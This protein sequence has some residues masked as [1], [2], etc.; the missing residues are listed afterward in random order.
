MKTLVRIILS[1][2][3]AA[4]LAPLGCGDDD[5]V[6]GGGDGGGAGDADSDGDSDADSDTGPLTDAYFAVDTMTIGKQ[7]L[8]DACDMDG[9]GKANNAVAKLLGLIPA[10]M[11]PK[12]PNETIAEKIASGEALTIVGIFGVES[13]ADDDAVKVEA[14]K[15]ALES[16]D[17]G[18]PDGTFSGHGSIAVQEPAQSSVEGATIV[19]GLMTTP[20]STFQTSVPLGEEMF[21]AT[22]QRSVMTGNFD[23]APGA[24]MLEGKVVNGKICGAIDAKTMSEMAAASPDVPAALKALIPGL[25][26]QAADLKCGGKNCLSMGIRFTAVS[27]QV[28]K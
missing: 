15:A 2:G 4:A 18:L 3:L 10:G 22:L 28:E 24:D 11:M 7:T 9:D 13:F 16:P 6:G 20:E 27:I 17:A 21:D 5:S 14:Y 1:V 12:D 23:P 26:N 19:G 8:D 25:I